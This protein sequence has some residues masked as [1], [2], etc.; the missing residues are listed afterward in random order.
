[1]RVRGG[2]GCVCVCVCVR[3]RV[4]LRLNFLFTPALVEGVEVI[5][6]ICGGGDG[7]PLF[8]SGLCHKKKNTLTST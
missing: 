3:A 1:M 8:N 5:G 6:S 2:G 7:V 4:C